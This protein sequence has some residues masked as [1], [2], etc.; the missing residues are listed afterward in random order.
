MVPEALWWWY[1]VGL[2]WLGRYHVA[3]R[4]SCFVKGF[5]ESAGLAWIEGVETLRGL[6]RCGE[7]RKGIWDD[8][9]LAGGLH[10]VTFARYALVVTAAAFRVVLFIPHHHRSVE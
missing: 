1:S 9:S 2:A 8:T 10:G 6:R 4:V 3:I 7:I 5:W